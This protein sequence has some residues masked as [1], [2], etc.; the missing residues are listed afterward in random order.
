MLRTVSKLITLSCT[1]LS[2]FICCPSQA[3]TA[4]T[5][6]GRYLAVPNVASPAQADLLSQ[7]FQIRFPASIT[8]IGDA[9]HYLLRFSGYS[10]VDDN[11]LLPAVK[12]LL[13]LPLPQAHRALGPL[14][15]QDGLLTLA[16]YP[17]GLIVDPVHRL[18]SFRVLTAFQPLYQRSFF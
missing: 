9:I 1:T 8:T 15:L 3:D 18:I 6:I 13:G 10:L 4:A 5:I 11:A 14:S 2:I 7:T 12:N 17:F 16:G